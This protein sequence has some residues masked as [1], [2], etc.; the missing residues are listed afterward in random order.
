MIMRYIG[1]DYG[2]KR[3]GVAVSD[4]EGRMA[5]PVGVIINCGKTVL[6]EII[7]RAKKEQAQIIVVGLPIGLDGKE[8]EQ[9]K[10]IKLFAATLAREIEIPVEMENE[11]FTSRMATESG[12]KGDHVDAASAA[13]ILQS[14]LDRENAKIK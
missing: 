5:F 12:M 10:K 11:M 6:R 1:I 9:T 7:E 2:S 14:Y 3:I 8:T 4:D 13:I